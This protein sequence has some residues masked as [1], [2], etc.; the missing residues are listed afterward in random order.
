[1]PARRLAVEVPSLFY[2]AGVTV[3][4]GLLGLSGSDSPSTHELVKVK[5]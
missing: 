5:S 4:A 3:V 1:M 2:R